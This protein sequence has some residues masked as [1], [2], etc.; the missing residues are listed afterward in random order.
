MELRLRS[1]CRLFD[2]VID[3]GTCYHIPGAADALDEI[4]R[5]LVPGGLF[6]H[7]TRIAQL[8][9]HPI[10]SQRTRLP[11]SAAPNLA[12]DRRGM[13]WARCIKTVE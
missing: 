5:V 9:A 8:F 4:A 2:V 10:R 1:N 11:W 7:E 12:V 3:F 13:L 6:V